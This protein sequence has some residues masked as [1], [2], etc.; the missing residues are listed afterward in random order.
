MKK[1]EFFLLFFGGNREGDKKFLSKK[2]LIDFSD[3]NNISDSLLDFF[4]D[5]RL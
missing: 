5:D 3:L 1:K 2:F 4:C